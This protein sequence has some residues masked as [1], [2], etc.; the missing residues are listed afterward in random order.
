MLKAKDK[1]LFLRF[2]ITSAVPVII[3]PNMY[4]SVISQKKIH[5]PLAIS[6][7]M[8]LELVTEHFIKGSYGK[9]GPN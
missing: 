6:L 8:D 2:L 7:N 3:H 5:K 1:S 9:A 4:F